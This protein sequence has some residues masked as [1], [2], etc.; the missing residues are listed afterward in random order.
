MKKAW[1]RLVAILQDHPWVATLLSF[2]IV[3]AHFLLVHFEVWQD[4]WAPLL[5]SP[6][7]GMAIYL[8]AASAAAIVAGFA[9]VV[10]V[11][12]LTAT[13]EK[14]RTLRL[15]AGKSLGSNWTSS[16]V[17]GFS[18]AGIALGSSIATATGFFFWSPWMLELSLLLLLHG[19]IRVIWLL[20]LL[21]KI[22][23]AQDAAEAK[24]GKT[25]QLTKDYFN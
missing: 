21:M 20:R 1:F 13:G 24:K 17:S 6:D 12:G 10:V 23:A 16:S 19:T 25:V 18:A 5:A 14:F 15:D 3:V 7:K 4:T 9:G 8:G 22:V 11:F 2:L